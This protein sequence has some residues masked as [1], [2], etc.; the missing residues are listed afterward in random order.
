M[1]VASATCQGITFGASGGIHAGKCVLCANIAAKSSEQSWD[2]YTP[3]AG[4]LPNVQFAGL[5]AGDAECVLG[6]RG[7]CGHCVGDTTT[8]VGIPLASGDMAANMR[9]WLFQPQQASTLTCSSGSDSSGRQVYSHLDFTAESHFTGGLC[10]GPMCDD[11]DFAD[12][13]L[14]CPVAWD[15]KSA[16]GKF[17]LDRDCTMDTVRVAT[18]TALMIAGVAKSGASDDKWSIIGPYGGGARHGAGQLFRVHS[19]ATLSIRNVE[20]RGG[21]AE[22]GGAIGTDMADRPVYE[23]LDTTQQYA[24][25]ASTVV[26]IA[27]CRFINNAALLGGA[28]FMN[29]GLL[30]VV[31]SHFS[32]NSAQKGGAIYMAKWRTYSEWAGLRVTASTFSA[33]LAKQGGGAMVIDGQVARSALEGC[34]FIGN[35]GGTDGKGN[36]ILM[37]YATVANAM[38]VLNCVFS[39]PSSITLQE[40]EPWFVAAHQATWQPVD[41]IAHTCSICATSP[42]D[43]FAYFEGCRDTRRVTIPAGTGAISISEYRSRKL[44]KSVICPAWVQAATVKDDAVGIGDQWKPDVLAVLQTSETL[45]VQRTDAGVAGGTDAPLHFDC[46]NDAQPLVDATLANDM[47]CDNF[48]TDASDYTLGRGVPSAPLDLQ[49]RRHR[50]PQLRCRGYARGQTRT[51]MCAATLHTHH[52][53][54]GAGWRRQRSSRDHRR[55]RGV[56]GRAT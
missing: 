55:R 49:P 54:R 1:C 42:P 19:G 8:S 21:S 15:C 36:D 16:E 45:E 11:A 22:Q 20:M 46:C 23:N 7:F 51:L 28:I 14:C 27:F 37:G 4:A 29:G 3:G 48:D 6:S 33:N 17:V 25:A 10:G 35:D 41:P 9:L 56:H 40:M 34:Q 2:T 5:G 47:A 30:V 52:P 50:V 38:V 13:G 31:S 43:L 26:S 39:S 44:P 24:V 53:R 18:G 12:G 32:G